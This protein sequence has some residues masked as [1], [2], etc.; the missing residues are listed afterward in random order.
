MAGF[1]FARS[2]STALRIISRWGR[3]SQLERDGTRRACRAAVLDYKPRDQD[4]ITPGAV[5]CLIAAK[6]LTI[7]PD[8]EQ[9]VLIFNGKRYRF[10]APIRGPK[11]NDTPIFYDC[12]VLYDSGDS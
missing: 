11:P 7:A 5:R 12:E 3:P 1:N 10:S 6:G 4:L 9:D 2:Q 8:R